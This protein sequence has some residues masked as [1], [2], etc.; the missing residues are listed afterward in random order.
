MI[1]NYDKFSKQNA[2]FDKIYT[3]EICIFIQQWITQNMWYIESATCIF[4]NKLKN[5]MYLYPKE[6]EV[7]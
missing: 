6:T 4:N 7:D 5:W 2:Q 1:W 3:L